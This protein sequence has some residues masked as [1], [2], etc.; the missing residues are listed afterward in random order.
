ML[1]EQMYKNLNK[2]YY[3]GYRVLN[4]ALKTC[5]EFYLT[6]SF[7]Y[8]A[9]YAGPKGSVDVFKLNRNAN[10]FN[11]NCDT[12]FKRLQA[13]TDLNLNEL[14]D[15]DWFSYFKGDLKERRKL[16][17]LIENLGYDGYFNREVDEELVHH[18]IAAEMEVDV[19]L[20]NSPSIG[21]FNENCITK[22]QT[23]ENIR[24]D[25]R[26][27]NVKDLELDYIEYKILKAYN[28]KEDLLDVCY[29]L[30]QQV[31]N[32]DCNQIMLMISKC[33]YHLFKDDYE[34]LKKMFENKSP[35]QDK[36]FYNQR[37]IRWM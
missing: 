26:V 31:L 4:P 7:I 25:Y 36:G 20:K 29:E 5:E 37:P 14:K 32:F 10:I 30:C 16:L 19:R 17:D 3:H 34:D 23:I 24:K 9:S 13:V 2:E 18:S 33:S 12:D 15:R 1:K 11:L 22:I 8:A 35:F 21:L 6:Q 27:K 28:E